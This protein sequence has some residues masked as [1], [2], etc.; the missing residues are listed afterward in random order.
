MN[1]IL[2]LYFEKT[3]SRVDGNWPVLYGV[4][5]VTAWCRNSSSAAVTNLLENELER[6]PVDMRGIKISQDEA[7]TVEPCHY[8]KNMQN[9][10]VI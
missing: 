6:Q 4:G 5:D 10:I 9:N 2:L 7:L 1:R 3:R 8:S